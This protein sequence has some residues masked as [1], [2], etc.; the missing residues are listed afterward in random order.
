MRE[1]MMRLLAT[2]RRGRRDAQF[3]DELRLHADEL[4]RDFERGGLDRAAA[5]A[6][7][8]RE[9]GGL[10][11]TKQAWR[12][13]R[14][15][16]PLEEVMQDVSYALRVLRRSRGLTAL[17]AAMLAVVVA[18]TTSLFTVL[19]AV[20]LAPLPYARANQLVVIFEDFLTQ[21]APNVSVTSGTL[22]EWQ[23]RAKSFSAF[24]AIE[25]RQQNLTSDGEP[26]Q[27]NVGAVSHGFGETIRTQPVTGRL[28]AGEEFQPGHENVA[29]VSHALW[30][31]RYS[32]APILGRTIV[33]DDRPYTV[34]GVMPSGFMFPTPQQQVWV[35]M[36]MNAAD[37]ENRTGHSLLA[38]A[39]VRDGIAVATADRELHDVAATL[40]R[41]FPEKKEW[42]VTVIPAREALVGKTT[43]VLRAMVG[44]VALL[45]LVACANVAG[46]LLT[47][48]VARSRELAVRMAIGANR[49]RIV[50]Q[51][52]T[53][54]VLLALIGALAGVVLAWLAQPLIEALR[55]A[56]LVTWKPIAID[57]RA[58][59][60]SAIVAL[61]CGALFGTFP[62]FAASRATLAATAS[63]RSPGHRASRV[64]QTLVAVEVALAVVLVAGAALLSQTLS[65]MTAVEPGFQPDRVVS[66]TV[67]LPVARYQDDRR[68]DLFYRSLFERLRSLPGVRAVGAVHALPL[69][70]NTSVRPY[71]VEGT[72]PVDPPAIAH[73][74]IV[75]PGYV[76]AMRIPLRA[77]RTF[78]DGDTADRPLVAIVN[79]TLRR[80]GWGTRNPIGTRMTFGGFFARERWAEVVGVVAD[81]RHFGPG[82]PPVA[83]MYWPAEQIDA[84]PGDALRRMRR[85]LTLVVS[86][87][88]GDPLAMVP[89][90]RAAVRGVDPDQPIANV[91]TMTSLMSASLWL[92]RVAAWLLSVFGGAALIFALLGVYGAASYSVAQRRRELAVRL[93]LGAKPER[94]MRLV[95]T[96]T[97]R[98]AIV[99]VV[100]GLVLVVTLRQTVASLVVGIDPSDPQTLA[101]VCASLALATGAACWFPAR[102]AS[103][104]DPMRALRVE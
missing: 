66:M 55:P 92:S 24:T 7:A 22:L 44:A 102:R 17:A 58:L 6:A 51:L 103:R 19:D 48:G 33:L 47:H 65:H 56:D 40:R 10:H 81:V 31:T 1:W 50:R 83:E 11:R 72:P 71:R 25:Q 43:G 23:E 75:M 14:S 84:V 59:A 94:V 36:P 61:A 12:D 30:S 54:S 70:G 76:E 104:I 29:L 90:V 99:G 27:V 2:G 88:A 100:V 68:V 52:L 18:A 101:L 42:G 69:S 67:A 46:L 32:G 28:F 64:R 60:F 38:V 93:A 57:A 87:D 96:S 78:T 9:L 85:G 15:W 8:E 16:L 39:R 3:D 97:L 45:L 80:Q 62:A 79:E 82:T 98:G 21:H 73:F 91:R 20:L 63:E 26:Q 77:G 89:S 37:R 13:Q 41:E 4:A 53:E 35:P 86:T 95:L 5:R 49:L 74:R 34:V